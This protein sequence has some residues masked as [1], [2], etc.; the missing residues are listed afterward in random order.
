[1]ST[2][3]SLRGCVI[4]GVQFRV[5]ADN[6]VTFKRS[7]FE[8]EALPTSGA[9]MFKM[10]II[11]PNM[12]GIELSVDPD[13][14]ALLVESAAKTESVDLSV[15][16]ADATEY[17]AQGRINVGDYSSADGKVE[18]MLMPDNALEGWEQF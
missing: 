4:D 9:S 13:E 5:T 7:P 3:G 16:L 12:E 14:H 6:D 17:K 8:T 18:V 15:T 11:N 1:M 2:S 10:T